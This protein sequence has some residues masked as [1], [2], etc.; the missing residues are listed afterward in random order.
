M[1][2]EESPVV[3]LIA[4]CGLGE[5]CDGSCCAGCVSGAACVDWPDGVAM[6]ERERCRPTLG[7]LLDRES[8]GREEVVGVDEDE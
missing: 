4:R 1:G 8:A 7:V 5:I 6:K 2:V 3:L